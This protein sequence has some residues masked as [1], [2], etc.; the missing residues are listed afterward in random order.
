MSTTK[1]EVCKKLKELN[2]NISIVEIEYSGSGDSFG[3]FYNIYITDADR[4]AVEVNQGDVQTIVEDY[5]FEIFDLSGQPDFNNDGSEGTITID[6]DNMITKLDNYR[7]YM[8]RESTGEE[9][10]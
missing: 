8:E 4:N 3:D 9:F 1:Q 7:L 2:P 6:V 5:C 10:F